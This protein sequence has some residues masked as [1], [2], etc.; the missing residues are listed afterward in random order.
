VIAILSAALLPIFVLIGVGALSGLTRRLDNQNLAP[1]NKLLMDFALP[2]SMFAAIVR[3]TRAD[4]ILQSRLL[5]ILSISLLGLWC[6]VYVV[7]RFALKRSS[8]VSA[9]AAISI[10]LPNFA[11]AGLPLLSALH[12]QAG[13]I[14][15]SLAIAVGAII[16]SPLTLILLDVA[17]SRKTN[18]DT[19]VGAAVVLA[20]RRTATAPIIL[21][22]IIAVLLVCLDIRL[23]AAVIS[24][25]SL[26]GAAAGGIA[27]ILTGVVLSISRPMLTLPVI[28]SALLANILHPMMTLMLNPVVGIYGQ[29][30]Q[31]AIVLTALPSGFF[32]VFFG[33]RYREDTLEA[34][35]IVFLST[36]LSLITLTTTMVRIGHTP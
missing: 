25:F 23:P 6:V 10:A 11:A 28:F 35:S 17:Q 33:L 20:F 22:P 36:V 32:G 30:A 4:L 2:A 16:L 15:A 1:L 9:I 29:S 21:V 13:K 14:Q 5:I 34:A 12:G 27:L 8:A 7:W 26:L 31:A 3:T 19:G 18:A 24:I